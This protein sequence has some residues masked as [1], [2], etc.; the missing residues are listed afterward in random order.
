M[1]TNEYLQAETIVRIEWPARSPDLNPIEHVLDMLQV[2]IS[3]RPV[4]PITIQDL[5][6]ALPRGMGSNPTRQHPWAYMQHEKAMPISNQCQLEPYTIL[7]RSFHCL[8]TFTIISILTHM[9]KNIQK[10]PLARFSQHHASMI[11]Q[12][13]KIKSKTHI[14]ISKPAK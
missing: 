4:K 10:S 5:R 12:Y 8:K 14:L 11:L 13:I 6:Q 2:A 9:H 1:V 7:K 3:A